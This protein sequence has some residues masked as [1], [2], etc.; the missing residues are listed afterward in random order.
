MTFREKCKLFEESLAYVDPFILMAFG[1]V[2]G[3][4]MAICVMAIGIWKG[5]IP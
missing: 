2:V 4:L 5:E 1:W 3:F